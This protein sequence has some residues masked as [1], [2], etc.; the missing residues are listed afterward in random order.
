M[1]NQKLL[2]DAYSLYKLPPNIK[3]SWIKVQMY[4]Y[5]LYA[6]YEDKVKREGYVI[7]TKFSEYEVI[8]KIQCSLVFAGFWSTVAKYM[9]KPLN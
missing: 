8:L 1:Y 4:K 3:Q 5:P 7:K 2:R 9:H 6:K